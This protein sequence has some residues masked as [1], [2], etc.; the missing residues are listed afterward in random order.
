MVGLSF[1]GEF[2]RF[3]FAIEANC[4]A[5]LSRTS[6]YKSA[7][8]CDTPGGRGGFSAEGNEELIVV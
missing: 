6:L 4:L 8:F 2:A 7:S 1:E 5:A 3:G